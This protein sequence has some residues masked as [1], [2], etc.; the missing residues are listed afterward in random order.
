M[1][2][3]LQCRC[4]VICVLWVWE[5]PGPFQTEV[6][7]VGHST[8]RTNLTVR[9]L[10][11]GKAVVVTYYFVLLFLSWEMPSNFFF[12]R[13]KLAPGPIPREESYVS[14]YSASTCIKFLASEVSFYSVIFLG[15]LFPLVYDGE[16]S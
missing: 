5:Q 10:N 14:V 11:S 13:E 6:T 1:G 16:L 8:S 12:K 15:T 4:A 7:L 2:W 3:V 9:A